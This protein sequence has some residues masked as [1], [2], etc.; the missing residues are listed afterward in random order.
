MK[1]DVDKID[2][3]NYDLCIVGAGP[4]GIVLA[5]EYQRLR[6]EDSILLVEYGSDAATTHNLLDDSINI[7]ETANHH[8]PYECTNKGLAEAPSVGAVVV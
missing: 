8:Q 7:V 6:P 5:L 4:A 2:R 3:K 1:I